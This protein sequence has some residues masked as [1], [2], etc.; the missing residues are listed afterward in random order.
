MV[1]SVLLQAPAA[2][3]H[4]E[5]AWY[6]L[7]GIVREAQTLSAHIRQENISAGNGKLI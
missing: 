6:P 7:D 4:R 3:S 2:L 1:T 5:K